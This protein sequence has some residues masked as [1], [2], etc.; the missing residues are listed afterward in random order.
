MVYAAPP[1]RARPVAA[2][3]ALAARG[4]LGGGEGIPLSKSQYRL[5]MVMEGGQMQ[6][7]RH[8]RRGIRRLTELTSGIPLG[9]ASPRSGVVEALESLSAGAHDVD[10][11]ADIGSRAVAAITTTTTASF[12]V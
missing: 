2:D 12:R 1:L 4:G 6:V 3:D 5:V 11:G 7:L 9:P 8:V 10:A